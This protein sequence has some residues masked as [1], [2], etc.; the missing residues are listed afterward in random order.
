MEPNVLE[1][2]IFGALVLVLLVA[3]HWFAYRVGKR[4][5]RARIAAD[6]SR[7]LI[8]SDPLEPE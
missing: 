7:Y 1:S 6:P 4:R 2:W 5:Q 3:F 8:S